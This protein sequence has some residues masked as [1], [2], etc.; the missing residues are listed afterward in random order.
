MNYTRLLKLKTILT[1]ILISGCHVGVNLDYDTEDGTLELD[2]YIEKEVGRGEEEGE[3][4]KIDGGRQVLL[5]C[6][7]V[8]AQ[9][10]KRKM[11]QKKTRQENPSILGGNEEAVEPRTSSDGL[12]P[13]RRELITWA[14]KLSN[15]WAYYVT[16]TF[17]NPTT[18]PDTAVLCLKSWLSRFKRG[19]SPFSS[20]LWSVEP[21]KRGT[22]H[23]HALLESTGIPFTEH[24]NHCNEAI[25]S[26][27]HKQ[28][29]AL[30]ESWWT[31]YG[32][33][34]FKIYDEK[35]KFGS[36]AYVTKYVLSDECEDWGLWEIGKD[37]H[38]NG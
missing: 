33:A 9:T 5:R 14:S 38:Y 26:H 31:H 15:K 17:R 24:C 36:I 21:Q 22:A 1:L 25:S 35:L 18:R 29:K 2:G 6:L 10:V 30:N 32:M 37:F 13:S 28:Y 27:L 34:R 20:L 19:Y 4:E 11:S 12:D 7:P 8:S 23:I 3:K 16:L